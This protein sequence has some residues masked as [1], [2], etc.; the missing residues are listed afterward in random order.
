MQTIAAIIPVRA[1]SRRL[2]NKNIL[3]FGDSNLLIHK[4]RQLKQV[5]DLTEIVVSSDSDLMLEMAKNEGVNIHKRE[6]KY[7]DDKSVPFGEV[8]AHCAEYATKCEH[9]MWSPCVCPLI[10]NSVYQQA[11]SLYNEYVLEKGLKDSLASFKELREFLWNDL[12]PIN[13]GLREKHLLSQNLPV[14]YAINN[15]IYMYSRE[16]MIKDKYFIGDN[17]YKLIL[18]KFQSIDIDERIDYDL[19]CFISSYLNKNL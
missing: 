14:F 11:I 19:A 16:K 9:I 5:K 17:P 18:D 4:I 2:P 15:A 10:D 8:V 3:P 1:G 13:Y 12:K 7:A 6:I